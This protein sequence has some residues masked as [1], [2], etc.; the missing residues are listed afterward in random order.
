MLNKSWPLTKNN[1]R[2]DRT[3]LVS[4]PLMRLATYFPFANAPATS[5][6]D[7]LIRGGAVLR[8]QVISAFCWIIKI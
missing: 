3:P 8:G 1:I 5:W 6:G 2:S 7:T 4:P